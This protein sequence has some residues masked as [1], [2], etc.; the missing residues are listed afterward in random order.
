MSGVG[1]LLAGLD[2]L[3]LWIIGVT[4]ALFAVAL[5]FTLLTLALRWRNDLRARA[6]RGLE[7]RWEP[8][9]MRVVVAD[10]RP[11]EVHALVQPRQRLFF[12]EYLLRFAQRV[13]GRELEIVR[14]IAAPY[15]PALREQLQSRHA[16]RR[17]RALQ[18]LARLG[19][20][21]FAA[22]IA[23]S[24][25]DPAPLVAM[26]AARGLASRETP[27]YAGPLV[28]SVQRFRHWNPAYLASLLTGMGVEAIPA[29]RQAFVDGSLDPVA[30]RVAADALHALDDIGAGDAA[31]E[32]VRIEQDEEL[33][34]ASLRLLGRIGRPE[35]AAVARAA[36]DSRSDLIRARA[37]HALGTLGGPQDLLRLR[38]AMDDEAPW[39]GLAAAEALLGGGGVALLQ[40]AAAAPDGRAALLAHEMV[41]R[42]LA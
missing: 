13:R 10:G 34:A 32:A 12:V 2:R 36:L 24:L 1:E 18:T 5:G 39:V 25:D 41:A 33:V 31:A 17:A 40:D 42:R 11:D 38:A 16:E 15:L 37:A 7:A 29:L 8:A 4:L 26:V 21:A 27:E 30:R 3:L 28:R 35:H 14:E 6:R 20:R 19:P 23:A 22:D 9:L